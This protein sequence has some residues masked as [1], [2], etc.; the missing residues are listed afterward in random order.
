MCLAVDVP[1]LD[2]SGCVGQRV[3]G[4]LTTMVVRPVVNGVAY[5]RR[6]L[7]APSEALG[8]AGQARLSVRWRSEP[9]ILGLEEPPRLLAS[10]QAVMERRALKGEAGQDQRWT[11]AEATSS[12]ARSFVPSGSTE[13]GAH[14][15]GTRRDRTRGW[16]LCR[17]SG[18]VAGRNES[19]FDDRVQMDTALRAELIS[20]AGPRDP[21]PHHE[22]RGTG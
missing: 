21:G 5:S 16:A 11:G 6:E 8:L 19:S 1:S 12:H 15:Q 3:S 9:V 17:G 20:L 4:D 14:P 2:H 10:G 7:G 22:E 18:Q 13:R